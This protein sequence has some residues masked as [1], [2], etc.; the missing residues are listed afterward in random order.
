MDELAKIDWANRRAGA[1]LRLQTYRIARDHDPIR[2]WIEASDRLAQQLSGSKRLRSRRRLGIIR[3]TEGSLIG[4]PFFDPPLY[5]TK[6]APAPHIAYL[7]DELEILVVPGLVENRRWRPLKDELT[8][9]EARALAMMK[10]GTFYRFTSKRLVPGLISRRLGKDG[11]SRT[12][13]V[14]FDTLAFMDW[15]VVLRTLSK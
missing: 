6:S 5:P 11:R 8:F 7:R 10:A 2:Q 14:R 4:L 9:D 13:E 12:N 1:D 3:H 15:A